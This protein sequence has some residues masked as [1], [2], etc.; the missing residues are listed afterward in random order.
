M[1]KKILEDNEEQITQLI[2]ENNA[3][4]ETLTALTT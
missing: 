3:I 2:N 4:K 1:N